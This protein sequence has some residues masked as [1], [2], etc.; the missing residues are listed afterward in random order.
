MAS[1]SVFPP[2]LEYIGSTTTGIPI[3]YTAATRITSLD[4]SSFK[5]YLDANREKPWIWAL[6]CYD[7]TSIF[8]TNIGFIQ[9]MASTIRTQHASSLQAVWVLNINT[10]MENLLGL[11][12]TEKVTII[13]P[14]RLELFV[15]LQKAGCSTETVD[16]LLSTIRAL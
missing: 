4:F 9:C 13:P 14:N 1:V 10:W 16:R 15:F 6:D 11:M 5:P 8:L 3:Y 2:L 12:G 7:M